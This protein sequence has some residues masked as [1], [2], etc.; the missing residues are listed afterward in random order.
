[1]S[2]DTSYAFF[3]FLFKALALDLAPGFINEAIRNLPLLRLKVRSTNY[4]GTQL[5]LIAHT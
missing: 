3:Y 5:P 1:M 2:C 4:L